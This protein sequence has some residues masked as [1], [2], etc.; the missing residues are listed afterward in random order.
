MG[1]YRKY[2]QQ[3]IDF[4][5]VNAGES[6]LKGLLC[7]YNKRFKVPLTLQKLK[8]LCYYYKFKTLPEI[9]ISNKGTIY[10]AC[11]DNGDT[12]TIRGGFVEIKKDDHWE[13]LHYHAWEQANGAIQQRH[14]LF[15]L[16][17]NHAN[18]KADNLIS[19]RKSELAWLNRKSLLT[20]DTQLNMAAINTARL[21]T[22]INE[23]ALSI[24]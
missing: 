5:R 9:C 7:K 19:L 11:Y 22:R 4:L 17:R 14:V 18:C 2:T 16:D 21:V 1:K 24:A 15:F 6:T 10:K 13:L 8:A 3:Q 23:R 20:K 12:R